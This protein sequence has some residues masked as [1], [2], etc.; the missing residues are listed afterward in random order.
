MG[1]AVYVKAELSVQ[2]AII[3]DLKLEKKQELPF[4]RN[5]P[6]YGA[7]KTKVQN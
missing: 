3:K 6:D 2:M 5:M 4:S 1:K 7:N